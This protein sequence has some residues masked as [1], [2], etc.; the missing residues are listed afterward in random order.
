MENKA[1]EIYYIRHADA[2]NGSTDGRD[3]CDRDITPLGEKQLALLSERFKGAKVDAILSSPLVRT[4]RT[5]AAAAEGIGGDMPIEIVPE[6]I[7]KGATPGYE[8]LPVNELKKY[9]GRLNLCKDRIHR[10]PAA[11]GET[12]SKEQCLERAKAVIEYLKSRF[13]F[14]QRIIIVSHGAFAINFHQAAMGISNEYDFRFT[15][16]NTAVTK[17]AFFSDGVRRIV[18]HNDVSHLIPLSEEYRFRI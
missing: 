5:A 9:Y 7:E 1:L 3:K 10:L 6:L 13:E 16:E 2:E 14:G 17:L 8:G 11:G 15:T 4:V 18:F 12:E